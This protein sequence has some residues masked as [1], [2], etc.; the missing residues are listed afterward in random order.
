MRI[1]VAKVYDVTTHSKDGVAH[2]LQSHGNLSKEGLYC[3]DR[4]VT[5]EKSGHLDSHRYPE[6]ANIAR[7][8]TLT[9]D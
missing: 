3:E 2:K 1:L 8:K 5:E 9:T 4:L 7:V 6:T